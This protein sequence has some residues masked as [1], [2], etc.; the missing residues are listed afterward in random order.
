MVL[1]LKVSCNVLMLKQV[2][3]WVLTRLACLLRCNG[4][5][6]S[7]YESASIRRFQEG[8]VDNIRSATL[9]AL[10]FV[11]SM[12]GDE[13]ATLSVSPCSQFGLNHCLPNSHS[14]I[15]HVYLNQIRQPFPPPWAIG[16]K[17]RSP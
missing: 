10:A 17:P 13:G 7:T 6:G 11:K 8:R 9:E 3:G 12:T 5:L 2:G 4:R 1:R 16:N 14:T 15:C